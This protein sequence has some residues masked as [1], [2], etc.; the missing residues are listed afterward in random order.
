M[1][2]KAYHDRNPVQFQRL[3]RYVFGVETGKQAIAALESWFDK[4]GTP[5]RLSQLGI[6]EAELP[7]ITD[8]VLGNAQWFGIADIYSR[9]VVTI[10]LRN[11]L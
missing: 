6:G 7:A 4:I 3:A 2:N 1:C 5:T 8:N 10:I 9:D 11:A